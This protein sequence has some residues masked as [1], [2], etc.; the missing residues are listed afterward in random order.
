MMQSELQDASHQCGETSVGVLEIERY[1]FGVEDNL[2]KAIRDKVLT[3]T[4]QIGSCSDCSTLAAVSK[5]LDSA[6][7]VLQAHETYPDVHGAT[8]LAVRKRLAPNASHEIQK[9]FFP[10]KR[11][12]K[13]PIPALSKPSS[14]ELASVEQKLSTVDV[15][16]CG[17][18]YNEDDGGRN[19]VVEWAKCLQCQVWFHHLCIGIKNYDFDCTACEQHTPM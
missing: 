6:I 7:C 10:T 8:T 19:D 14:A 12:C 3:L 16:V 11:P 1:S 17:V 5:H 15:Q 4:D 13:K 9:R 2:K 18:C